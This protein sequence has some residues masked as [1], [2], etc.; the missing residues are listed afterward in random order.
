MKTIEVRL[1][2]TTPLLLSNGRMADPLDPHAKKLSLITSKRKKTDEN[3]RDLGDVEWEGLMY[4]DAHLGPYIPGINVFS[5]L[6][7]AGA[8]DRLKTHI[9]RGVVPDA[10]K[11]SIEYSGPRDIE[12]LKHDPAYRYRFLVQNKSTGGRVPTVKPCFNEWSVRVKVTF[13]PEILKED[14]VREVLSKAGAFV[15]LGASRKWGMGRFAVKQLS[16]SKQAA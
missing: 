11:L 6:K 16:G 2:G 5:C 1:E 15:G 4:F 8:I 3:Y 10:S 13:M 14:Q 7:E 9:A 12:S